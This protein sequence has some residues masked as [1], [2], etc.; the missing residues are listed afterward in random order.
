[1][2]DQSFRFNV[3]ATWNAKIGNPIAKFYPNYIRTLRRCSH[4]SCR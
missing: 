2:A 4:T 1:M 3:A